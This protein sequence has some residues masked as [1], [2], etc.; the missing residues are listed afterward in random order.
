MI[1]KFLKTDFANKAKWLTD[2]AK[3]IKKDKSTAKISLAP[4][5]DILESL[6]K[7]K[8]QQCLIGFA[9]ES[10][11]VIEYAKQKIKKKN[12]DFI[13]ANSLAD[14]GAGFEHDTNK[15]SII[16]KKGKVLNFGLKSK[17]LV[18]KDILNFTLNY[19]KKK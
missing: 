19:L 8:K 3:K 10:E 1:Q 7:V 12:L 5:V 15:I 11:N 9:L 2:L 14:K 6:G 17:D 16:D 13:V 18:A 4:T